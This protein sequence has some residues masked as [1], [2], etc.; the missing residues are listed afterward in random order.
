MLPTRTEVARRAASELPAGATDR[1]GQRSWRLSRSRGQPRSE[2]AA[3]GIAARRRARSTSRIVA[4]HGGHRVDWLPSK[5]CES[6]TPRFGVTGRRAGGIGGKRS[7]SRSQR[8]GFEVLPLPEPL[9]R[10]PNAA[11]TGWAVS[12]SGREV[13]HHALFD[14]A[15][16]SSRVAQTGASR[17]A[18]CQLRFTLGGM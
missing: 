9:V 10:D 15:V 6:S 1:G 2:V 14:R 17:T 3:S 8:S 12:V 16:A 13:F 4:R 11:R 5:C 18:R 7:A